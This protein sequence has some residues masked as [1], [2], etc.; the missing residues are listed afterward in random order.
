MVDEFAKSN[1]MALISF[2]SL[3]KF[4]TV[5]NLCLLA[6]FTGDL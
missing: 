5:S 2:R 4:V 3:S 1:S 6:F